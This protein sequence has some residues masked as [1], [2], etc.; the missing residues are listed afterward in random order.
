MFSGVL[1]TRWLKFL[2]SEILFDTSRATGGRRVSGGGVQKRGV[3]MFFNQLVFGS[4]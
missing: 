2:K 1:K 3:G 4:F